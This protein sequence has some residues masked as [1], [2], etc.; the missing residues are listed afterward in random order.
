MSVVLFPAYL[1]A[2][3]ESSMFSTLL[4][5]Q[6]TITVVSSICVAMSSLRIITG[7]HYFTY[8]S[9]QSTTL[10]QAPGIYQIHNVGRQVSEV[11]F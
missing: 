11:C 2:K 9:Y 1:L 6:T 5:I 10:N 4:K 7:K 8:C 3:C